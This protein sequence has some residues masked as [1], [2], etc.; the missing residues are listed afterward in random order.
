MTATL[1]QLI[2]SDYRRYRAA[3]AGSWLGTWLLTQGLWASTVYRVG[4]R[5]HHGLHLPL[6]RPLARGLCLLARKGVEILTGISLPAECQ[7]GEGIYFGHFGPTIVHDQVRIGRNCNLSQGVT[8]GLGGRG[9]ARGC[10][11]LGDRV[12]V[13]P[14]AVV[15]GSITIGHDAAIGA[16]AVVT[17]SVPARAVVVGNPA[18][19][20]SY[21]GSF[22][23]VRY[24]GM[25]ADPERQAAMHME[26]PLVAEIPKDNRD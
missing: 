5:V 22:D 14:N 19:V 6:L 11:S 2:R 4:S 15:F 18:R 12:Y 16:G 20:I 3:G 23:F 10:P 9:A 8:L 13:G 7:V 21:E 17:R 24:D 1:L 26:V 25:E